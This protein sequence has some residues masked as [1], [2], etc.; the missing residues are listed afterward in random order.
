M[1]D[2]KLSTEPDAFG[3]IYGWA[4]R[5]GERVRVDILPPEHSNAKAWIIYLDGQEFA[6]VERR[7][8]LPGVLGLE[9]PPRSRGFRSRLRALRAAVVLARA[10]GRAL[11]LLLMEKTIGR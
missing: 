4:E 2:L 7:E 10:A 3:I 6:H 11:I 5:N 9:G 8:D 1:R